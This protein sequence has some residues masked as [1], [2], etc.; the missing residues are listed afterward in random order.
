QVQ[1]P[2]A[3][4]T[5]LKCNLPACAVGE[6]RCEGAQL[7]FCSEGRTGWIVAEECASAALCSGSLSNVGASGTPVCLPPACAV[8]QHRCTETG[9]LQLCSE[10]RTGFRDQQACIGAPF[11]N[12][13]LADQG[14]AGCRDAPCEAGQMQ[15]NG[16][17]IQV[18]RDD[19][20]ALDDVGPPCESAALCN[21]DDPSNAVCDP[22]VCRRGAT[23]GDEFHCEG[24]LLQRCNESLTVYDTIQ[25][26][27]TAA[28]CDASQRFNGCK[29]PACQPGRHNCSNGFLQTCNADQTG[30]DNTENCGSQAQCDANAGRCADPCEPGATR[31]N[32]NTGDLELCRDR[33]TGWQPIADCQSLALCDAA[34]G[35]C[36]IC[37]SGEFSC[38]DNQLRQCAA[39]GRT[40]ARQNIPAE[41][42]AAPGGGAGVR[43]CQNNQVVVNPCPKG[44]NNGHCNECT[45]NETQCVGNGQI[46]RC[47][48][49]IFG[50][51]TSCS[52]GNACNGV[53]SCQANQNNSC[54]GGQPLS[55]TDGNPCTNDNCNPNVGCQFPPV[56]NRT[57]CD[58][59]SGTLETCN[60]GTRQ[61]VACGQLGC[62]P[63]STICNNCGGAGQCNGNQFTPCNNGRAGATVTC[64]DTD[65]NVCTGV[66]CDPARGCVTQ[67]LSN[68]SCSDGNA[69]NGN[70]MC[71]N[72]ACSNP[73]DVGC[74]NLG[75]CRTNTCNPGNGACV[76]GNVANGTGCGNGSTCQNGQCMAPAP[77]PP[78]C[79][80][81]QTTR[82][83]NGVPQRCNAQGNGFTTLNPCTGNTRHACGGGTNFVEEDCGPARTCQN[84]NGQ[85]QCIA[86]QICTPSA[87]IS[88]TGNQ[89]I[90]CSSGG[91]ATIQ[92]TCPAGTTC[93]PGTAGCLPQLCTPGALQQCQGTQRAFCDATGTGTVRQDCPT[94]MVCN[95]LFGTCQAAPAPPRTC[96]EFLGGGLGAVFTRG[97]VSFVSCRGTT[98]NCATTIN[99]VRS[100]SS[101]TC[102]A[103]TTCVQTS[104]TAGSCVD[105]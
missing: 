78:V 55:C 71:Q 33:L 102:P 70:E 104:D 21:A 75:A 100:P 19:R 97:L 89:L 76:A 79:T 4:D 61:V 82:C 17:Q 25:T 54:V 62:A 69:C 57:T 53:E 47:V 42:A 59:P 72:G 40:F 8:G 43:G 26:C 96:A 85:G 28:L 93:G 56:P 74:P 1:A 2:A 98:I 91:A 46:R 92:Q 3:P 65:G 94:G 20:T 68:I 88:C 66:A 27:V 49:G 7:E 29:T 81:N 80:A 39:D 77:P 37:L 99:D 10:D 9:V 18:C 38:A 11:C 15:C 90:T 45:V 63:G 52:D 64:N 23:S 6:V 67:A 58:P 35:R 95:A 86:N 50:N 13:V 36:N 51:P 30:C 60:N 12:A 14:Q 31:C 41:C 101:F 87:F 105:N 5:A 44:C 24:A 103:G 16:A 32:Q 84:Q 83:Q 34:D 73:P 48:N 22:P